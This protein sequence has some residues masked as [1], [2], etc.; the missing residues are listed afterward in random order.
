MI[1]RTMKHTATK[2]KKTTISI[3]HLSGVSSCAFP[4][5]GSSGTLTK[6][7]MKQKKQLIFSTNK[8]FKL[9]V[10]YIYSYHNFYTILSMT[11]PDFHNFY[12]YSKWY[13][14]HYLTTCHIHISIRYF[15]IL[16]YIQTK[17][18]IKLL[19]FLCYLQLLDN[20]Y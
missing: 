9:L 19:L 2:K 14:H 3:M 16:T 15:M 13:Q 8:Y 5:I 20:W 4:S 11:F 6:I 12:I 1:I 7:I 17:R 18:L 10:L